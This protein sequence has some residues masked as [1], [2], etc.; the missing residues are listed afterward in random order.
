MPP[1]INSRANV[2]TCL[3]MTSSAAPMPSIHYRPR[4]ASFNSEYGDYRISDF[5]AIEAPRL[6]SAIAR[7]CRNGHHGLIFNKAKML[8][9]QWVDID[10][11]RPGVTS[12]C[13]RDS[14]IT[15]ALNLASSL[16]THSKL[17]A[18]RLS[19][20]RWPRIS[21]MPYP[22]VSR[23]DYRHRHRQGRRDYRHAARLSSGHK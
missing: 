20:D 14:G 8:R 21:I 4:Q 10:Y 11:H 23:C 13:R 3:L 17:R 15:T 18:N 7:A 19:F 1:L 2:E 9:R 6:S 16:T 12:P 5:S 22:L